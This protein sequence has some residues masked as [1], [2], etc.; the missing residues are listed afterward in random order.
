MLIYLQQVDYKYVFDTLLGKKRK[1][2]HWKKKNPEDKIIK[3]GECYW[4]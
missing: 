3:L 4:A 2:N 1:I